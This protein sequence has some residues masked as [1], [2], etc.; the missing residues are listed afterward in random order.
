MIGALALALIGCGK[1][2]PPLPTPSPNAGT[3]QLPSLTSGSSSPAAEPPSSGPAPSAA[4]SHAPTPGK[5]LDEEG[6]E[7]LRYGVYMFREET[8]RYPKD[9][10]EA[11]AAGFIE[12]IPPAPAGRRLAY[13]ASSGKL[14]LAPAK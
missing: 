2:E 12:A 9:L 3:S 8:G 14:E 7:R 4:S 11:Q 5:A 1:E 6:L 10:G 13:D